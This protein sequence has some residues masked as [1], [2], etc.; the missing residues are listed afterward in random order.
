MTPLNDWE[1]KKCLRLALGVLLAVL[2]LIWLADL[3]F[4]IPGLR[5]I[6]S[7][8]FLT[9]IPGILILRILKIH[10]VGIIESL[11]YSVGLSLTFIMFTGLVANFTLPLI[12]ISKPISLIPVTATLTIFVLVLMAVAYM[13]DKAFI[14]RQE[15]TPGNKLPLT[16]LLLLILLLLLTIISVA[17]ID[18]YQNNILLLII[19]LAIAGVI[20]LAAFGKLIEPRLYPLVILVISLCLLYQTTLLSPYLVGTD[21]YME[22]YACQVVADNG[23]WSPFPHNQ[24]NACLS[25]TMLAPVYSLILNVNSIWIF[26]AVYPLLFSLVP[27]ILFYVFSQQMSPK[28]AFLSAFFFVIVPTFSLEMIA[29]CRQQIAELFLALTILLMVDRKLNLGPRLTLAIIFAMSI[30]VSHYGL[31]SITFIYMALFLPLVLVIRRSIFR[32]AWGW[33]TRKSGGLPRS[34][35]APGAFPTKALL[36]VVIIYFISG[37]V[38]YGVTALGVLKFAGRVWIGET[39]IVITEI[40]GLD[41]GQTEPSQGQIDT[42]QGQID[43]SQGQTDTSQGQAGPSVLFD[44]GQRDALVQTGLGLDFAQASPQG[45]G[46]RILQYVTQLFLIAGLLRLIFRPK[47]LRFT[48]EYI[49]LSIVSV[50]LLLACILLPDFADILNTTRMYH[51]ALITLAPFYILGGEAIWVGVSYLWHKLVQ[52]TEALEFDGDSQGY[53]KFVVLVVLIPYFLFTSGF[54]YEVTGQEVTDKVD[55]PYSIALSSYRLDLAALFYWQ[56]GA[57]AEWLSQ[58]VG[59]ETDVYFDGHSIKIGM[60]YEQLYHPLVFPYNNSELLEDTYI[61]FTARNIEK[62]EV[63][64]ITLPG[65]RRHANFDDIPGLTTAIENKSRIYNNGGAQVLAPASSKSLTPQ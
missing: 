20:G 19:I 61:Y 47:H 55:T 30:V 29:L 42:S 50:L 4:D 5:Q 27:L 23:F 53:P 35:I 63:T 51:I 18:S 59:D 2:S 54:I 33:L 44:F 11:V 1:I 56:D 21:I 12:G 32:R 25:I 37:F 43:T 64:F 26:K 57:A 3:G 36:I 39:R 17:L 6:A 22:H 48:A 38:W 40:S 9:F 52:R 65:L 15:I 8:I 16:P 41:L 14:G 28:K 49:A 13:R 58:R 10:N 24:F 45:K 60:L 34:L 62:N 31:G 7:F 46:F